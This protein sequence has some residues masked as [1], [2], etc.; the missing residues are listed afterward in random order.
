M[1]MILVFLNSWLKL[2]IFALEFALD[3]HIQSAKKKKK[4]RQKCTHI[5]QGGMCLNVVILNL[6]RCHNYILPLAFAITV[7][8]WQCSYNFSFLETVV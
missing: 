7:A 5:F 6:F 1:M 4:Q 3:L 2:L 8:A